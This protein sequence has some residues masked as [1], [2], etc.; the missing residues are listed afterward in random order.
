VTPHGRSDEQLPLPLLT[1]LSTMTRIADMFSQ[2]RSE[3]R[4]L[5][6]PFITAGQPSLDRLGALLEA[7]ER[8]G[9]AGIE[10]GIPFSDPIADGP[11]I[12]ASMHEALGRGVTPAS[13]FAT[14]QSDGCRRVATGRKAAWIAMVSASIVERIGVA[15]FVRQAA[16]AGIDGLIVPDADLD[17]AE[18]LTSECER[19]DLSCTFLVAPSSTPERVRRV[20]ELC[21]GFVY[22]LARAGVTGDQAI[23]GGSATEPG[24]LE[25]QVERIRSV[26]P[27][28]PIAAGFGIA[29]AAHVRDVLKHVDGAIVGTALVRRMT[30]AVRA[31]HDPIVDAERFVGEL[32]AATRA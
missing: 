6:L 5:V 25:R 15:E 28:L 11:V 2:A 21:R 18:V 24:G 13:V 19:H 30:E 14:L 22:L 12:A 32:V 17:R 3:G 1:G 4:G 10:L 27:R 7:L 23:S 31:G 29:T 20:V 26:N 8:A 16:N 9:A